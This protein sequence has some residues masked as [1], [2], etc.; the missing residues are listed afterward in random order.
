MN[1]N[2]KQ[3]TSAHVILEPFSPDHIDGLK[4]INKD[5][6]I[7]KWFTAKLNDDETLESWMRQR[8]EE[9]CRGQKMTYVVRTTVGMRIAGTT[10]Y[11]KIN[12]EERVL[13]IGWTW[14]GKAFMGSGLNKHMKFLMLTHAF[15]EM[16]MERVEF[17]TD[18]KNVRS[19][20]A[21]E[22]TGATQ[23]GILRSERYINNG[24][25]RRNTVIYSIVR[26]EWPGIKPTIFNDC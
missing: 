12:M 10:S 6:D 22:K 8:H 3:L 23:E 24:R 7:W 18:E 21:I 16:D 14:I 5:Q 26:E 4:L 25:N 20:R 19:R 17:R 2:Y 9:T 13:E 11:G 15:E 1:L